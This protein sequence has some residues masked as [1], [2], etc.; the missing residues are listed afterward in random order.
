MNNKIRET[1][2]NHINSP[3][4]NTYNQM[5]YHT[6]YHHNNQ[7]NYNM[8]NTIKRIKTTEYTSKGTTTPF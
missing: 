2:S 7:Q 3:N 1:Q 6:Q 8:I 5:K 4:S